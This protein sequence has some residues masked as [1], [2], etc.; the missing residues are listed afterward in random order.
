MPVRL[1]VVDGDGLPM[2]ATYSRWSLIARGWVR[3][4]R[5]PFG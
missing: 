2:L 1:R 3:P 5:P 4:A